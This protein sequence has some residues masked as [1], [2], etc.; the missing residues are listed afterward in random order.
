MPEQYKEYTHE[1]TGIR[2]TVEYDIPGQPPRVTVF[3][4]EPC[5]LTGEEIND[6]LHWLLEVSAVTTEYHNEPP[7]TQKEIT[8]D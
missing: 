7:A 2:F 3:P 5:D 1:P 8:H 4:P 6:A